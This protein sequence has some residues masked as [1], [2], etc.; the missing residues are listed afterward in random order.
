MC[1]HWHSVQ[2]RQLD[3]GME[4]GRW[5]LTKL[6]TR[7]GHRKCNVKLG[8]GVSLFHLL[9]LS[10]FY[11]PYYP[12][13]WWF[14]PMCEW[15]LSDL[16]KFPCN[17]SLFWSVSKT[18]IQWNL[19]LLARIADVDSFIHIYNKTTYSYSAKA[20]QCIVYKHNCT[21]SVQTVRH[22]WSWLVSWLKDHIQVTLQQEVDMYIELF[23]VLSLVELVMLHG[24]RSIYT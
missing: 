1:P 8:L 7:L 18:P 12:K 23:P 6:W 11:L 16:Y 20:I 21:Y 3:T 10:W 9:D 2:V 24:A 19:I 17:R 14:N 5:Q 22:R 15:G 13:E 4:W